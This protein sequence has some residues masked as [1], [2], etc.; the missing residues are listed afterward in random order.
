MLS[1]AIH[2]FRA[3][4]SE[5]LRCPAPGSFCDQPS[6]QTRTTHITI[7]LPGQEDS[8]RQI[9][10]WTGCLTS[11]LVKHGSCTTHFCTIKARKASSVCPRVGNT[12][13]CGKKKERIDETKGIGGL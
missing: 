10:V 11:R 4:S 5:C 7:V 1:Y 8:H 13:I 9:A 12:A 6:G 2:C 3:V